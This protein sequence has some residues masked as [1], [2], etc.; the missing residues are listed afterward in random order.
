[1]EGSLPLCGVDSGLKLGLL[2][3][4]LNSLKLSEKFN[5]FCQV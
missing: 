1:M 5:E 4:N 2:G 3:S